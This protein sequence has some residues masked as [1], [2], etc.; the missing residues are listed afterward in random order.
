MEVQCDCVGVDLVVD[1]VD[2]AL[3]ESVEDEQRN[4]A[5]ERATGH[6]QAPLGANHLQSPLQRSH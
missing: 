2:E 1:G 3:L 5:D 6:Q 4:E